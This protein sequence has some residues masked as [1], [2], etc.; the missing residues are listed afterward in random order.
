MLRVIVSLLT[1]IGSVLTV[2]VSLL[3]KTLTI[4]M[5]YGLP[6]SPNAWETRIWRASA[7]DLLVGTT[8]Y[9]KRK[10]LTTLF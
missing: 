3:K 8:T 5:R 2:I 9:W 6:A 10:E 7:V 4:P 1:V